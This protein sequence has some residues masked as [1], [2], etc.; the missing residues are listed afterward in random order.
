[1]VFSGK[2]LFLVGYWKNSTF[3]FVIIMGLSY[4]FYNLVLLGLPVVPGQISVASEL[5]HW[6]IGAMKNHLLP[7]LASLAIFL[8]TSSLHAAA[9][10]LEG[11]RV[12]EQLNELQGQPA[13][14]LALKGWINA[15]P[16]TLNKLKGKIVVLDF[17]GDW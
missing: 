6:H 4:I 12:R 1:M 2:T 14:K 15:E 13:P 16:M 10:T 3:Q 11:S 5:W 7:L 17:W 9:P 8:T